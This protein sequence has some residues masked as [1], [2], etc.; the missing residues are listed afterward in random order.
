[1]QQFRESTTYIQEKRAGWISTSFA[2]VNNENSEISEKF[3]NT[4]V[5]RKSE[6]K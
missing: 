6:L 1:M 4:I 2:T 3:I 5:A